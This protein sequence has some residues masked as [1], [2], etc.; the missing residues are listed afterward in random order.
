MRGSDTSKGKF[1]RGA[2]ETDEVEREIVDLGLTFLLVGEGV[3]T[4][5]HGGHFHEN[6][7]ILDE[8]LPLGGVQL[9]EVL[10]GRNGGFWSSLRL[11]DRRV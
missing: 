8:I 4:V 1:G 9:L 10:Q 3:D 7:G 2:L 6:L 11:T 5:E